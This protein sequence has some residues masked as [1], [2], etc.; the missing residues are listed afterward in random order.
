MSPNN[1]GCDLLKCTYLLLILELKSLHFSNGAGLIMQI[2][3]IVLFPYFRPFLD[4][5]K[6]VG[7]IYINR[8]LDSHDRF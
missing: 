8:N 7:R 5:V 3:K 2:S 6:L 1:C 4:G